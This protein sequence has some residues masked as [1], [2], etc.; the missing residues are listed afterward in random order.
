MI[1]TPSD[2]NEG[3]ALL[4]LKIITNDYGIDWRHFV[5]IC[6]M[7]GQTAFYGLKDACSPKPGETI[8]I[9]AAAGA[10]GHVLVQL[11][12]RLGLKVIASCGSDEKCELV[13][14]LGADHTINYKTQDI[15]AELKK[16]GPIDIY[17]DLVAGP[18]LEAAVEHANKG[19]R[20]LICGAISTYNADMSQAYGI[21]NLWL[22][23]RS[24]ITMKGYVVIDWEEKYGA[25][26]YATM[27]KLVKDGEV[28]PLETVYRSLEEGA[29]G[30]IDVLTGANRGKAVVELP[31]A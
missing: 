31:D 23:S 25:E 17:F 4:G 13:K 27:P 16:Y 9:P 14:K 7:T 29:Q 3:M 1:N 6:G 28:T 12:K 22:M 11:A 18:M 8:L 5:G 26:F 19:C 20:I 21:K 24:R 2:N 30:M 15:N 10:V